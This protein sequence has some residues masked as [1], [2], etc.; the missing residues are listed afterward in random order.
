LFQIDTVKSPDLIPFICIREA[1]IRGIEIRGV[2][3]LKP[4]DNGLNITNVQT[5]QE[6]LDMKQMGTKRIFY[7]GPTHAHLYTER[8]IQGSCVQ[9]AVF[10]DQHTLH[11]AGA[12]HLF[13]SR[14][15]GF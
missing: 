14:V 9:P 3:P 7:V 11:A 5:V 12:M 8:A 2:V 1:Q 4:I 15:S 6:V 10:R 13:M